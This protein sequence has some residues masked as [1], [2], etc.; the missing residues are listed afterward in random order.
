MS[1]PLVAVDG[2][3]GRNVLCPYCRREHYVLCQTPVRHRVLQYC[4]G[5]TGVFVVHF[6]VNIRASTLTVE[7]EADRTAEEAAER[8]ELERQRRAAS[9]G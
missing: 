6:D 2:R 7:G 3:S 5:C 1:V 9:G 4:P 8:H